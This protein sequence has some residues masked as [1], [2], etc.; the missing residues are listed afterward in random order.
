MM[1]PYR[2]DDPRRPTSTTCAPGSPDPLAG[3]AA[4][5]RVVA[6]RAGRLPAR[7][8]RLLGRR[9]RLARRAKARINELPQFTTEIDGQQIHFLHVRSPEPGALPLVLSH[10]WPGSIVEFLDVIGPLTDPRAHGGDPADAFHVVIPSIPG[11][12]F[13][14]QVAE[15][16]WDSRRIAARVRRAD[17]PARLR[18]LRRAGRRL[19]RL[20]RAGPGPG[21]RRPRR[22]HPRQRGHLRLHPVRR[23]AAERA[24]H[25]DRRREGPARPARQLHAGHERLLP[26]PGDPAAD[27]GV[28]PGRLA[29]RPARLDRREVP[30]VD[31]RRQAARGRRRPR[32]TSSPT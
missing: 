3:R 18:A 31:P 26:D 11:F 2:I 23:G 24:G 17:A 20:H 30:G 21:R 16:G 6:R 10:G 7:A 28:R 12:G 32:P 4:R 27:P 9:L 8:G 29:G 19:R 13:S 14:G 5:R 1:N 15:A 25:D 22:R